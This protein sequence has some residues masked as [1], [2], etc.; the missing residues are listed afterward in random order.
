[1][2]GFTIG[3]AAWKLSFQIS[4]IIL[5]NG[6][7]TQ[8]GLLPIIALTEA[9]N[10]TAGILGDGNESIELDNFFATFEVVS[11]GT[12]IDQQIGH[13]PFANQAVAA[14]AVIAQPLKFSMLMYCPVK[15]ETGYWAKLSTMIALKNALTQHNATGGTYTVMTPNAFYPDCLLTS[16]SDVSNSES[17]QV[18]HTWRWDFEQPLL[19]Q[20]SAQQAYNSAMSKIGS[21]VQTD[22][23]LSGFNT[24]INAPWAAMT[25][26]AVPSAS[27]VLGGQTAIAPSL[28]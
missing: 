25:P 23:S 1:M 19:T 13:Y 28:P 9:L 7:A 24:L 12:I 21:G 18:Q 3:E 6:I 11:G 4:P 22:G 27:G 8:V 16:L 17:K 14:N 15:Q 5:T 20:A 2:S 10:F 26:S